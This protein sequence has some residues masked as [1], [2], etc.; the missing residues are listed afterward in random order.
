MKP[1]V[2]SGKRC[3][4]VV[5]NLSLGANRQLHLVEAGSRTLVIA[6]T[7][8]RVSL[9]TEID[10]EEV[11]CTAPSESP[12]G[13]GEQLKMF[14]GSGPDGSQAAGS[15]AQALRDSG[16]FLRGKAAELGGLRK[17]MRSGED[18]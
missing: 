8:G 3:M 4:R 14:M 5:E 13:F 9:I 17:R 11:A 1:G 15:V 7:P 12:T 18:E 6:S 2:E 16:L 10:P